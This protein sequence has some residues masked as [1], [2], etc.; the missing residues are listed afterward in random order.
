MRLKPEEMDA[1]DWNIAMGS[2]G[3]AQLFSTLENALS[4]AV[5]GT[6]GLVPDALKSALAL[7]ITQTLESFRAE[8]SVEI[9]QW[10]DEFNAQFDRDVKAGKQSLD[11]VRLLADKPLVLP[12]L[13]SVLARVRAACKGKRGKMRALSLFLDV[14]QSYVSGWLRPVKPIEPGGEAAFGMLAWVTA[15]E[16]QPNKSV[17]DA[18]TP[19]TPKTPKGNHGNENT[20]RPRKASQKQDGK[21]S[22]T[23]A[24]ARRPD[25]R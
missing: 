25:A 10:M 14:P 12:T 22:S 23:R 1:I 11:D 20:S 18:E 3:K 6:L 15:E 4:G 9:D 19:T 13:K 2:E 8:H 24:R 7:R 17:A 21:T 16:G 5:A